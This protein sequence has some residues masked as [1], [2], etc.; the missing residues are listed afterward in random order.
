M[1]KLFNEKIEKK[2]NIKIFSLTKKYIKELTIFYFSFYNWRE[3]TKIKVKTDELL[4]ELG[5]F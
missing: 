4:N 2:I 1:I 3:I 5:F